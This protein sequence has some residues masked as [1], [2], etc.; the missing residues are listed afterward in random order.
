MQKPK[1]AAPVALLRRLRL[2][3]SLAKTPVGEFWAGMIDMCLDPYDKAE[4]KVDDRVR[5]SRGVGTVVC[6]YPRLD[7][8]LAY[9]VEHDDR[10]TA[11]YGSHGLSAHVD[12]PPV[13]APPLPSTVKPFTRPYFKQHTP[14]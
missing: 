12:P 11:L 7:G 5:S 8:E 14:Q 4:W 13:V 2:A 9:V 6:V 10:T 3:D 1:R